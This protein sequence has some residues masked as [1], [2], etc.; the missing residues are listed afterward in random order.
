MKRLPNSSQKKLSKERKIKII[1]YV[2]LSIIS[3]FLIVFFLYS[4]IINYKENQNYQTFVNNLRN[5]LK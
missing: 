5:L 3:F 2:I 4:Y 1:F